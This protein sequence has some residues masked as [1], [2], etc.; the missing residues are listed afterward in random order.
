MIQQARNYPGEE[1]KVMEYF[2]KNADAQQSLRA[3]IFEDKVIG[4]ILDKAD[5]KEK[6]ISQ[7]ALEKAVKDVTEA[8]A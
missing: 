8:E 6:K 3:P 7:S 1:Q 2:Q 5:V 4:M